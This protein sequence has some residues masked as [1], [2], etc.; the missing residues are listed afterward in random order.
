LRSRYFRVVFLVLGFIGINM[1]SS[2]R[3][4]DRLIVISQSPREVLRLEG[5]EG[6]THFHDFRQDVEDAY[7]DL[8]LSEA[9]KVRFIWR[10]LGPL[11][12]DEL[13]CQ[14][15]G[16]PSTPVELFQILDHAFG[17][18]RDPVQILV[19]MYTFKQS[20]AETVREFSHRLRK[21][22][23]E[24]QRLEMK[25]GDPHTICPDYH[26]RYMFVRG[27]VD[28]EVQRAAR[29][30]LRGSPKASFLEVR[31]MALEL[32]ACELARLRQSLPA[33]ET[34]A[35]QMVDPASTAYTTPENQLEAAT[36]PMVDPAATTTSEN[37][38][39][40]HVRASLAQENQLG[41]HPCTSL[42][43]QNTLHVRPRNRRRRRTPATPPKENQLEA[44]ERASL[45]LP[46]QLGV[47]PRTLLAPQDTLRRPPRRRRRR[48]TP[49]TM[50]LVQT[51]RVRTIPL[52]DTRAAIE[53]IV[54]LLRPVVTL[55]AEQPTSPQP[56]ILPVT[57]EA[58]K[59]KIALPSALPVST[60]F[61]LE[62]TE[63]KLA[64][65]AS[66]L[67][68]PYEARETILTADVLA[69]IPLSVSAPPRASRIP[70]RQQGDLCFI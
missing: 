11:P 46:N 60:R 58:T 52:S 10:Q 42:A 21:S 8:S 7:E 16:T 17:D 68:P 69:V 29:H 1:E 39:E 3:G 55:A 25:R 40:A 12:R 9:A 62:A 64:F 56:C 24:L 66:E 45:A 36:T 38:L 22:R 19:L 49:V 26:L 57:L 20:S 34:V 13:E 50:Q 31:E 2:L 14:P 47:H 35:A 33:A 48:R 65:Y 61:A 53:E 18:W 41:V 30:L 63:R 27:L 15:G 23:G 37:Q 54:S 59:R 44:H 51:C 6:P 28:V 5:G 70:V 4:G 67:P 32:E 43:P